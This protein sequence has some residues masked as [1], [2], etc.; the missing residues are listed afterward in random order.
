MNFLARTIQPFI[1][2]CAGAMAYVV[3]FGAINDF[4]RS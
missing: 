2:A 4:A 3:S 1:R